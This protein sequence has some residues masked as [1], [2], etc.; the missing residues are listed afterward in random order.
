MVV[1]EQ[2]LIS[3]HPLSQP[4]TGAGSLL[5]WL[6]HCFYMPWRTR[7][8]FNPEARDRIQ[9]AVT[10]AEQGHSGEI[11]V[12]IEGHLPL[13]MAWVTSTHSRA[14]QLFALYGVWDTAHN[15]GVLLYI[16]LCERQVEIV[17]DRGI[18]QQVDAVHWQQVCA[19]ISDKLAA[20]L[21]TDAVVS[22]I[23]M[24][25]NTLAEFYAA[26]AVVDAGNELADAALF[27]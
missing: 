3:S 19:A 24:L 27:L 15:S 9:Q 12:I 20:G 1:N 17:A 7:H 10:A 14:Q 5:R 23:D 11:Q 2:D 13:N 16:N 26:V 25:G 21:Y 8:Y 4:H 6:R 18:N 22:G